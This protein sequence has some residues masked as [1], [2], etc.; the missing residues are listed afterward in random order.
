[1]TAVR[2]LELPEVE[3]PEVE[4]PAVDLPAELAVGFV[5]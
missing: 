3:L 4:L 1:M 2:A 5:G